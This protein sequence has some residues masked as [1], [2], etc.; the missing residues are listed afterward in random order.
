MSPPGNDTFL[1]MITGGREFVALNGCFLLIFS[2]LKTFH[3]EQSVIYP[4]GI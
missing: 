4:K 2:L 1:K 3:Y